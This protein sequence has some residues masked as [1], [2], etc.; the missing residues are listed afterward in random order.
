MERIKE[1]EREIARYKADLGLVEERHKEEIK[2][3]M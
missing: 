1:L 2:K 3:Q